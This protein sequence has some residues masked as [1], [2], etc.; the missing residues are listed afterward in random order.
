MQQSNFCDSVYSPVVIFIQAVL[1]GLML[2]LASLGGPWQ[3]F[4]GISAGTAVAII[5]YVGQVFTP[6]S[7]IGMEIQTSKPRRP[8]A[9]GLPTF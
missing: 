4:F 8:A 1:T 2:L 7:S 3:S 5:A 9:S 6:L